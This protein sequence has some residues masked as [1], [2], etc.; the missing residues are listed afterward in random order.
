MTHHAFTQPRARRYTGG[1]SLVE[2]LVAITVL[3]LAVLGPMALVSDSLQAA[4]VAKSR[5][6]AFFLAQEA[7]EYTRYVRDTIVLERGSDWLRGD[8]GQEK[9]A[10]CLGQWCKLDVT[11]QSN[12]GDAL[13]PCTYPDGHTCEP[14][15]YGNPY[16][17]LSEELSETRFGIKAYQYDE[18]SESPYER[19]IYIE[20]TVP[21]TEALVTVE[22][23]YNPGPLPGGE[24]V[25]QEYMYNYQESN[26]D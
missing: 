9:L 4:R 24:V 1:F 20:E 18:G 7:V 23:H 5:V 6:T 15:R 21:D 11:E 13:E 26:I 16:G 2:T 3:L 12:V 10:D 8:P 22:V 19:R 14:L 17:T 25:M